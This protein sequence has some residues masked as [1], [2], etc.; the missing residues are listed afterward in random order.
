MPVQFMKMII[1]E[2]PGENA[3]SCAGPFI[4]FVVDVG[5]NLDAK[6]HGSGADNKLAGDILKYLTE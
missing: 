2:L 3:R 5:V 1:Q 6:T 4:F